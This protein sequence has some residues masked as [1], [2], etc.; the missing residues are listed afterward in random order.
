MMF[1]MREPALDAMAAFDLLE[2]LLLYGRSV[3]ELDG[4]RHELTN[5]DWGEVHDIEKC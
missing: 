2:R 4:H 3:A 1:L 5:K